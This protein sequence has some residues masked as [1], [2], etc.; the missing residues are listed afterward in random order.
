M[1]VFG[2][3]KY[4]MKNILAIILLFNVGWCNSFDVDFMTNDA[5]FLLFK[6]ALTP[7]FWMFYLCSKI[8]FTHNN[9]AKDHT[10]SIANSLINKQISVGIRSLWQSIFVSIFIIFAYT[11]YIGSGGERSH[12]NIWVLWVN[13]DSIIFHIGWLLLVTFVT[14]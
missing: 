7:V 6:Y 13:R 14:V 11:N 2:S 1:W 10:H 9:N 4:A 3:L 8:V 12:A 5:S